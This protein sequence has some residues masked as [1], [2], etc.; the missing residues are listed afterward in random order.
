[1]HLRPL[2]PTEFDTVAAWAIGENWPGANKH[3]TMTL[4]EFPEILVRP[5]HVSLGLADAEDRI[6]GFGQ[7]WTNSAGAINL[8]RILVAPP[9]RGRGIGK[10]LCAMLLDHARTVL[11]ASV[12]KLRVYRSNLAAVA[13]YRSLGF[14]VV[15]G[16]SNAEVLAMQVGSVA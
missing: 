13:V 11:G 12:V 2:L 3:V 14:D 6:V 5:G 7:I 8:V 16:E 10:Q 9:L 4:A 1:M 15:E